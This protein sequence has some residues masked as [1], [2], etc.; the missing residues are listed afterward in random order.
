MEPFS[1]IQLNREAVNVSK[2]TER[3]TMNA[4]NEVLCE[5]GYPEWP[6]Q[7]TAPDR[8]AVP[9][10]AEELT[11]AADRIRPEWMAEGQFCV[12]DAS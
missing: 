10:S 6:F 4:I 5:V 9:V 12:I 3:E 1:E 2:T 8:C 11:A 7:P